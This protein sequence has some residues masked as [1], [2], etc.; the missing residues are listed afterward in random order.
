MKKYLVCCFIL[1]IYAANAQQKSYGFAIGNHATSLPITGYPQLFYSNFHPGIDFN[2]MRTINKSTKNLLHVRLNGSLIY[3][4]F[5]QTINIYT[6]NLVY[7]RLLNSRINF[8][9]SLGGGY[10]AAFEGG[11]VAKLNNEGV[12]ETKSRFI[13]RSQFIGQFQTGISYALK[14]DNADGLRI[15]AQFRTIIQGPFVK[16]YVP[17]LPVNAFL[18]GFQ[19][20]IKSN[21]ND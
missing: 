4:R 8:N 21:S 17:L 12:Y 16:D 20:P 10:G 1:F 6:V 18:L 19:L 9:V 2:Y 5:V 3:Q 11:A 15:T 7:D 14:K 13:P